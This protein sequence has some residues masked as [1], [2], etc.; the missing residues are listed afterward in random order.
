MRVHW[1]SFLLL[2]LPALAMARTALDAPPEIIRL[3]APHLPEED[4][5]QR[6][7]RGLVGEI[8]ATEGYFSPQLR[9]ARQPGERRDAPPLRLGIEAGPRTHIA[10]V[11]IRID[12]A[13]DPA[14]REALIAGWRL[15]V[16]QPFRQGAWNDAKQDLLARLLAEEYPAARL[17]DSHAQIDAA[18]QRAELT[19]RYAAGP[20]YVYRHDPLIISGLTRYPASLVERYNRSIRPGAAYREEDLN[21]LQAALQASP[22]FSAAEVQLA[23]EAAVAADTDIAGSADIAEIPDIAETT[24]TTNTTN[25]AATPATPL[26]APVNVTLRE[27][28]AHRLSLGAGVSSNTGMRGEFAYATPDFAHQAWDLHSGL[29]LEQKRQTLYADIFLPPD[30]HN[31]RHSLGVLS[32]VSDIQGL[33]TVRQAIGAQ[34]LQTRGSIEQLL[35]LNWLQERRA[36]EG[37]AAL[38]NHALVPNLMLTWRRL[39]SLIEPR[40]GT[41]IQAQVG[42]ALRGLLS[43]TNFLR[44]SARIQHYLPLGRRD[45]LLL[46]GEVGHTRAGA[47]QRIPQDYLFRTGGAG[48]VRGYTYQSLGVKEGAATVGG[49]YLGILS[50]EYTHWLD[51][52]WDDWGIATFVDA[53]N[54]SNSWSDFRY[55]TGYGLGARWRSPAGPIGADLA[56]GQRSH[57]LQLHFSLA[58]PF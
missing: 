7:L 44:L 47:S 49:R 52:D 19:L 36:P 32:E 42:G 1:L 33:R 25:V 18:S 27:R 46:R 20:R 14:R 12:G 26:Q 29:R 8:L 3:I 40:A 54:A 10:Q 13:L 30:A 34:T 45:H 57:G 53:G 35:S 21:Q 2:G 24:D 16:G 9:F 55:A 51:G 15:P 28:P 6:R 58:I 56:Y 48:T 31:R 17:V 39:D 50:A 37:A 11:D 4:I 22:Y 5:S 41:V 43:D 38:T 23:R